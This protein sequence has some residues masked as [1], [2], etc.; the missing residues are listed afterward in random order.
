M[1]GPHDERWVEELN[2][3]LQYEQPITSSGAVMPLPAAAADLADWLSDPRKFVPKQ[4]DD[5]MQVIR[6]YTAAVDQSGPKLRELVKPITTDIAALLPRLFCTKHISQAHSG[7]SVSHRSQLWLQPVRRLIVRCASMPPLRRP[8]LAAT[9]KACHGTQKISHGIDVDVRTD[10]SHLVARLIAELSSEPA[11]LASWRDLLSSAR[12]SNRPY[13]EVSFRRDTLSAISENRNLDTVGSFGLFSELRALLCDVANAVHEEIQRTAGAEVEPC[14][15]PP[16]SRSG[17]SM[18]QRLELCEQ[19]LRRPAERGNCIAWVRVAPASLPQWEIQHGQ[20]TFYAGIQLNAFAGRVEYAD[21]FKNPPTEVL[22][23]TPEEGP[24]LQKGE[25]LWEND[26]HVVYARVVLHDT[27]IHRSQA[28]AKSLVKGLL[29]VNHTVRDAWKVSDGTLLFVDGE[30]RSLLYPWGS[31]DQPPPYF[32]PW[33][34]RTA[35]DISVM[36]ANG[37]V[38]NTRSLA[39]LQDA[40]DMTTGLRA[41]SVESP[42]ATVISAVR[43][44]EH[45]NAW[46]TDGVVNWADFA[47]GFF[48]KSQSI[49]WII[50]LLDE[51]T[52]IGLHSQGDLRG[53]TAAQQLVFDIERKIKRFGDDPQKYDR[54]VAAEKLPELAQVYD[55]HWFSRG[56]RE[57]AVALASPSA[58]RTRLDASGRRF[59]AQLGRLKRL[60]NA[61]IHGGPVSKIA[62]VSV[63][64]FASDLGQRCLDES[65]KALLA[66]TEIKAHMADYRKSALT[67]YELLCTTGNANDLFVKDDID[68]SDDDS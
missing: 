45:V 67:R 38:L 16:G 44:I 4:Y 51:Y 62:C 64:G 57:L 23:M 48:K 3:L 55:D 41:A 32:S 58:R 31:G 35:R 5:W 15:Y 56:L 52:Q 54:R 18:R 12:K 53:N 42:Q 30:C 21:R 9:P 47:K 22:E 49:S 37:R 7:P 17:V 59:D 40:I 60:R 66:G 2:V 1:F 63:A 14:S 13:E 34:D 61:A 28:V 8:A 39:D 50:H 19:L 24:I 11:I 36:E 25:I 65:I 29:A 26:S 10:L 43:A 20:V 6:D 46:T 33:N 68:P 27:E